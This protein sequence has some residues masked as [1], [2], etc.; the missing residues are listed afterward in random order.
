[1]AEQHAAFTGSIPENY[2]RYLGPAPFDPY[3]R[4]FAS[5]LK[6]GGGASGE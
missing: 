1:V 4:D 2:D 5:R 6:V 3:A